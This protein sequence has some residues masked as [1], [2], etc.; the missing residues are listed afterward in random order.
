MKIGYSRISSA[1]QSLVIQIDALK[2]HG[3]DKI[4]RE[5]KSGK[6]M[7]RPE[8]VRMMDELREGD[9]LV[10]TR[11]DRLS[12]S[13][14]DLIK[15]LEV[16][17]EKKVG[18][19]ILATDIDTTTAYGKLVFSILGTIGEFERELTKS[20]REEGI[21]KY[22]ENGGVLGRKAKFP[23]DKQDEIRYLHKQKGISYNQLA[24]RFNC[25]RMT[26]YRI[27]KGND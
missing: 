4:Y 17:N 7:F 22:L 20:R 5:I 8:F 14:S 11:L 2:K 27:L 18:L 6:N 21:Q 23:E 19:K 26:I 15:T 12:R 24:E 16:L 25:S 3:C 1:S 9:V 13:L 10:S